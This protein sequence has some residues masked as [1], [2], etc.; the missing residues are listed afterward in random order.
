MSSFAD[1]CVGMGRILSAASHGQKWAIAEL[2]NIWQVARQENVMGVMRE[3][4]RLA[5]KFNK[6]SPGVQ[7]MA[8]LQDFDKQEVEEVCL[9]YGEWVRIP[10]R[11]HSG[12]W[13]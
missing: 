7:F 12:V 8:L 11:Y 5:R 3:N 10:S 4:I 1:F 6:L 2:S 9:K 13:R